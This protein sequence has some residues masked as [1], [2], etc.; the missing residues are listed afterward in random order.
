MTDRSDPDARRVV[1]TR[2]T[3]AAATLA[4]TV[5]T[6][7]VWLVGGLAFQMTTELGFSVDGLGLAV[8]V[9]F[10]ASAACSVPAGHLVQ[11]WG[12]RFGMASTSGLSGAALVGLAVADSLTTL[13]IWV[14]V[15]G[16]A[17][18]TCQPSANLS[19]TTGAA[20]RRQGLAFGIKQAAIPVAT[21][22]AGLA[23][24]LVALTAGW[25]W[26]FVA[27][28]AGPLTLLLVAFRTTGRGRV[29]V[30]Q[31]HHALVTAPLAM[32]VLALAGGLGAAAANSFGAFVVDSAISAGATA[33][34][35]GLALAAGS[36]AGIG[37]RVFWG[38]SADRR[39]GGHLR[40]VALL[41]AA[42]SAL[43]AGLAVAS[44]PAVLV[45]LVVAVYC[46]GWGWPGLY[47]FA[48]VARNPAAAA[49]AS[50]FLMTGIYAGGVAG[51][52]AFGLTVHRAGYDAAW[53]G[54]ALTMACAAALVLVGR[55]LLRQH[56]G[57]P[58][59][60]SSLAHT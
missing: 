60:S 31:P 44:D 13:V 24:P 17:N 58:A 39:T 27:A 41:M 53:V 22:V 59:P 28:L 54:A 30:T 4:I 38:W 32:V 47:S 11:R 43:L 46:L 10:A 18:S 50:G 20:P 21:L 26:A 34:V 23:V 8:A 9:F 40:V 3:L 1:S 56:I 51:P 48:I 29:D 36:V 19:L 25:R 37:A 52:L 2:R 12:P 7:P 15:A 49:S 57:R 35:A 6:L 42:G 14:G 5:G 16:V 55:R 33:G 45:V